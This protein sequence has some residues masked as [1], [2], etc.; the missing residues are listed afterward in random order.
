MKVFLLAIVSSILVGCNQDHAPKGEGSAAEGKQMLLE[1]KQA[2]VGSV[3]PGYV[4]FNL[5]DGSWLAMRAVDSHSSADGGTLGI[6]TDKGA[7]AVFFTHICGPGSTP[8]ES[9]L[10]DAD[11]AA[12]VLN[13]L[14]ATEKEYLP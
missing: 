2:P 1:M 4:K 5:Q 8:L 12:D 13:Q 10:S 14:R 11:S 7:I 6:V 9:F 3:P